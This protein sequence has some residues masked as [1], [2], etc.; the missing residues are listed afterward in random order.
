MRLHTIR[1][2]PRRVVTD[3]YPTLNRKR[4]KEFEDIFKINVARTLSSNF[5]RRKTIIANS[6][7]RALMRA[8]SAYWDLKG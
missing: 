7:D 1:K 2:K 4:K 6:A 8:R 3:E 5:C